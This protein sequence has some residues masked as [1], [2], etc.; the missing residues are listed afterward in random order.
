MSQ[1]RVVDL[2]Q[3]WPAS[4]VRPDGQI[5][6]EDTPFDLLRADRGQTQVLIP[7]SS[8][9]GCVVE[10]IVVDAWGTTKKV[11]RGIGGKVGPDD[12]DMLG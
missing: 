10:E 3:N 9:G 12:G 6:R 2:G 11:G 1:E 5:D 7:R 4:E 8:S